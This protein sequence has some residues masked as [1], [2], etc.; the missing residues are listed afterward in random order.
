ML[1]NFN[2]CRPQDDV[3][4]M[5]IEWD[6]PVFSVRLDNPSGSLLVLS[7]L[8]GVAWRMSFRPVYPRGGI[9]YAIRGKKGQETLE[10]AGEFVR[11]QYEEAA[12]G[13]ACEV[14][15]LVKRV[16]SLFRAS[17]ETLKPNHGPSFIPRKIFSQN[18]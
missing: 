18:N 3:D 10:L 15:Y 12:D 5:D 9:T 11:M 16:P 1:A 4:N 8:V 7:D 13:C 17:L 6:Q 2:A 14:N